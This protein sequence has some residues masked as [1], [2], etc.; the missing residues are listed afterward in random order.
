MNYILLQCLL[1]RRLG[2][3]FLARLLGLVLV[4]VFPIWLCCY[5]LFLSLIFLLLFVCS[6][7]FLCLLVRLQAVVIFN[8]WHVGCALT[9]YLCRIEKF[10]VSDDI[11]FTQIAYIKNK[12]IWATI[13]GVRIIPI[14]CCCCWCF[15]LTSSL[16][17]FSLSIWHHHDFHFISFI[18]FISIIRIIFRSRAASCLFVY[19]S[20]WA[21]M[22]LQ[23]SMRSADIAIVACLS[24]AL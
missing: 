4:Y 15:V 12:S 14:W 22:R 20:T 11:S 5:T 10:H 13:N 17:M 21:S 3:L 6:L 9:A 24:C 2:S 16:Y 18:K 1:F 19:K 23:C 7:L 8:V